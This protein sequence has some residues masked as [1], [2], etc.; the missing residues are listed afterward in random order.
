MAI[1]YLQAKYA[2]VGKTFIFKKPFDVLIC[3]FF[4]V[5]S[6]TD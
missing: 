6:P 5:S 1:Y 3:Y 2:L 4:F